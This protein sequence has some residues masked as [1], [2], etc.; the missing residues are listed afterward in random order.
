MNYIQ[1]LAD[2]SS[3]IGTVTNP[4]NASYGSY[5]TGIIALLTNVLRLIFSVTGAFAFFNIIIA[6]Y[7]YMTAAG[8]AK[9]LTAA[10]ARIWQ[11]L[12]GLVILI[13]S[14]VLAALFGYL[15]FGDPGFMLNPK[16]YGPG[17]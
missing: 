11:S 14:F 17:N 13:G 5:N 15:I 10:W 12:I 8:D 2:A 7:Q 16:I 6:G 4:M 3:V 9:A 1:V